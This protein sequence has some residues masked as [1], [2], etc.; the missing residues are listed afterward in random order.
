[1]KIC[2]SRREPLSAGAEGFTHAYFDKA[3]M[4]CYCARNP[5]RK[6]IY[7]LSRIRRVC[8]EGNLLDI[9]C[10]YG[11]FLSY[12]NAYY[13]CTGC[14]VD[15]DVV[16]VARRRV[17][18]AR[19]FEAALPAIPG[20]LEYDVVTCFD[21]LEHVESI[22]DALNNIRRILRDGGVLCVV[23]PV[24]DGPLGWIVRGLDRDPT[25]VHRTGREWWRCQLRKAGFT[26]L[27]WEGIVRYPIGRFYMHVAGT[28]LRSIGAA[29]LFVLRKGE[30]G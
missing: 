29:C 7:Y 20:S 15:S 25:H 6:M 18:K 24:Y 2:G 12:A 26:E 10:A 9:G 21:V 22:H 14:D 4:G 3:Y 8:P 16:A 17:Q 27:H 19:F 13:K 30:G 5:R 11:V 23:V 28:V 1:M